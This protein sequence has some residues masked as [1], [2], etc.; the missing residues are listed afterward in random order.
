VAAQSSIENLGAAIRRVVDSS[1]VAQVG[2]GLRHLES[3]REWYL[4]GDRGFLMGST[5]KIAVSVQLLT[6]VDQGRERLDRLVPLR[7]GDIF[8]SGSLLSEH[9]ADRVDPGVQLSLRR[10]LELMLIHSDNS[11]TDVILRQIGG[12]EAVTARLRSL[13]IEGMRVDRTVMDIYRDY[14]GLA[15]LPP[16]EH[17]NL[18]TLVAL[19]RGLTQEQLAAAQRDYH[20][21]VKD[22]ASPRAMVELLAQ[23][24]TGRAISPASSATLLGIMRRDGTGQGRIRGGLPRET[25]AATKTGTY[26]TVVVNDVGVIDLPE[27]AGHL[28]LAVFTEDNG[29][30]ESAKER[31][32]AEVARLA[33]AHFVGQPPGPP[34]GGFAGSGSE[35]QIGLLVSPLEE[36]CVSRFGF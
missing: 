24:S 31:L 30:G 9:F 22:R 19:M 21:D 10:Y 29:K 34:A 25:V 2:V 18:D 28:V 32:I 26:G 27:G 16:F 20:A 14:V 23:V 17:R 36:S 3:G 12:P 35:R 15:T 7:P 11:A 4:S 13:G 8:P 6:L 5:F 1:G 33:F